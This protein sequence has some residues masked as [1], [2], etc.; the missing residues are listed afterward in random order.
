[1]H[2]HAL[3]SCYVANNLFAANRV[4]T[5]R[6]IH[7]QIVLSLHLQRFRPGNVQ[8][9]HCIGHSAFARL[10]LRSRFGFGRCR[11][12]R[13]QLVQHLVRAVFSQANRGQQVGSRGHAKLIRNAAQILVVD[14][15]HRHFEFAGFAI[16]QLAAD[17]HRPAGAGLRSASV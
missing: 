10:D 7:Q 15:R 9:A 14:L 16:Q 8:P 2:G 4:A 13:R 1:M 5:S 11:K 3:A 17:F 12:S 6:A